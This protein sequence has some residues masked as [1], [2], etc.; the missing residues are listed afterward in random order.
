[1]LDICYCRSLMSHILVRENKSLSSASVITVSRF[2]KR[3]SLECGQKSRM[4]PPPPPPPGV[5]GDDLYHIKFGVLSEGAM[6][7][8]KISEVV[9]FG[10]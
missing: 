9:K 6:V 1:M 7:C 5:D 4:F 3:I 10:S 8:G 2:R